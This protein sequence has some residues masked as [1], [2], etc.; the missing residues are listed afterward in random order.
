MILNSWNL[1]GDLHIVGNVKI[2]IATAYKKKI[3]NINNAITI[4][5]YKIISNFSVR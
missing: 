3:S 2:T 5:I 1:F 4:D